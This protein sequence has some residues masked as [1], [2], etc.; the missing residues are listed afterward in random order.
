MRLRKEQAYPGAAQ[1]TGLD[2]TVQGGSSH[3]RKGPAWQAGGGGPCLARVPNAQPQAPKIEALA[4]TR[5]PQG[6]APGWTGSWWGCQAC[7]PAPCTGRGHSGWRTVLLVQP[8]GYKVPTKRPMHV[9]RV[10]S[11][12]SPFPVTVHILTPRANGLFNFHLNDYVPGRSM[13]AEAVPRIPR[14]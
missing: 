11:V 8:A 9:G 3:A 6:R 10:I 14:P 13:F 7:S 4:G 5:R 2:G 12:Q 1:R